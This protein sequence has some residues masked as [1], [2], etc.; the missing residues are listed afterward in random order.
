MNIHIVCR[1]NTFRSRLAEGYLRK[2]IPD[3][4]VSSSG[5]DAF[6]DLSGHISWYAQCI[7]DCHAFAP[8]LSPTW[9]RTTQEHLNSADILVAMDASIA[10]ELASRFIIPKNASLKIWSISDVKCPQH[11]FKTAPEILNEAFDRWNDLET[12]VNNFIGDLKNN[13]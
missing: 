5:I 13:L 6:N 12:S 11:D 7:A 10:D 1:G 8:H 9:I 2:L 3:L 4:N